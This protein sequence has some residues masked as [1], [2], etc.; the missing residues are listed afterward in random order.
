LRWLRKHKVA[1]MEILK[2]VD[3][4]KKMTEASLT[5]SHSLIAI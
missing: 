5:Y 3:S 1:L 2:K 4:G